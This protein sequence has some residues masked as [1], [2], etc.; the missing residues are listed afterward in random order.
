MIRNSYILIFI[1]VFIISLPVDSKAT[2]LGDIAASMKAGEWRKLPTPD[3]ASDISGSGSITPYADTWVWNPITKQGLFIGSCHNCRRVFAIY[4]DATHSWTRKDLSGSGIPTGSVTSHGYDHNT[5]NPATGTFYW[6]ESNGNKNIFKYSPTGTWSIL[7]KGSFQIDEVNPISYYPEM[8][9]FV[10]VTRIKEIHL[11]KESTQQ[12]TTLGK[13]P[14]DFRTWNVS[15]Y[16]PVHKVMII[17]SGNSDQLCKLT[18]DGTVTRLGDFPQT[19]YD[20]SGFAGHVTVDPV[21]GDYIVLTARNMKLYIYDV[22]TD[23]WQAGS[24]PPAELQGTRA[25]AASISTYGVNL[26]MTCG[27][28]STNC[29]GDLFVYKHSSNSTGEASLAYQKGVNIGISPNPFNS[30]V[31]IKLRNAECGMRN[32]LDFGIYNVNGKLVFKSAINNPQ[33]AIEWNAVQ[34]P[35]GIY[36]VSLKM[37]NTTYSK[38]IFLTR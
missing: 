32:D 6:R 20:G 15:E 11:F 22:L 26:F 16:N 9:G 31:R 7:P 21:S 5:I 18:S 17:G 27:T 37:A 14:I 28:H 8:G 23:K 30:K 36:I 4:D 2:V 34:Y 35:A 3:N 24:D 25:I 10:M 12:W 29:K 38:K 19:I 33:S 1:Y 13:A